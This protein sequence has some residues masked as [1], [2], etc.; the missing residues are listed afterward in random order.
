MASDGNLPLTESIN[1][2]YASLSIFDAY[3]IVRRNNPEE[4]NAITMITNAGSIVCLLNF[5]RST[6]RRLGQNVILGVSHLINTI[7]N[8]MAAYAGKPDE[9]ADVQQIYKYIF[10]YT[11]TYLGWR[12]EHDARQDWNCLIFLVMVGILF[13]LW[14][15]GKRVFSK[16]QDANYK[17]AKVLIMTA[18]HATVLQSIRLSYSL[19]YAFNRVSSLDPVTGSFPTRLIL[20]FGTQLCVFIIVLAGG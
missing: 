11:R 16:R 19:T 3:H 12:Q 17:A 1:L 2:S 4:N 9:D 5:T 15:V 18:G 6:S 14:T 13:W 10:V 7:G 8:G 20:M